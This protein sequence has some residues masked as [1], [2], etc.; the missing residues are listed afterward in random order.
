MHVEN[1][2]LVSDEQR[3]EVPL[4]WRLVKHDHGRAE[5]API[6]VRVKE[7]RPLFLF[8]FF[9]QTNRLSL[10]NDRFKFKTSGELSIVLK[11]IMECTL[12]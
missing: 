2:P 5:R 4:Q 1:Q 9:I 11:E 8:Y 10:G 7:T 12:N 6:H 3:E